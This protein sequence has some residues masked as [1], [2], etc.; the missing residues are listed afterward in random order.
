MGNC[1]YIDC[2]NCP[3]SVKQSFQA[4]D[5]R[6]TLLSIIGIHYPAALAPIIRPRD[7][8]K[9]SKIRT[10]QTVK[11]N[12]VCTRRFIKHQMSMLIVFIHM[13]LQVWWWR[14]FRLNLKNPSLLL[15]RV[16]MTRSLS[17]RIS[18]SPLFKDYN[19][20]EVVWYNERLYR[21]DFWP[22]SLF[23]FRNARVWL[24]LLS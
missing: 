1:D 8:H 13:I 23:K 7:M 20:Q 24:N 5:L 14:P 16:D 10:S 17:L 6:T 22:H 15:K 9:Y 11:Y 4:S 12:I 3:A 19:Y 2:T 21:L 18:F